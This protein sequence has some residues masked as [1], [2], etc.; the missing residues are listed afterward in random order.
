MEKNQSAREE[1]RSSVADPY[2]PFGGG[3]GHEMRLNVKATVGR[4]G[5]KNE[6]II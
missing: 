6:Y 2:I 1:T 3:E 4:F 5:V